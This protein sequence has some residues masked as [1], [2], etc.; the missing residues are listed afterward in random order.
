MSGLS[1][2]KGKLHKLRGGLELRPWKR[3]ST[4][5]QIRAAPTTEQYFLRLRQH[6]GPPATPVVRVGDPVRRWQEI[7]TSESPLSASLHA[8]VSGEVMAV[9]TDEII[10]RRQVENQ[11]PIALPA[12]DTR[13][14]SDSELRDRAH[15][16][17]LV[18]LGGASFP[19]DTKLN[20]PRPIE[21][22]II[23]GTECEPYITSDEML[24]RHRAEGVVSGSLALARAVNAKH[25]IVAVESR[26]PKVIEHLRKLAEND[27]AIEIV[28]V[29][30]RFP[31]G[32]ERQLTQILFWRGGTQRRSSSGHWRA[33]SQRCHRLRIPRG[34]RSRKT[35]GLTNRL[36]NWTRRT[37]AE[38]V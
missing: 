9:S 27:G 25:I 11:E 24:L 15:A 3:L 32:G 35:A 34:L 22:L 4:Q 19:T 6:P 26:L 31:E 16:A 10:I 7:A 18:G 21:M 5:G 17:G 13:S 28:G 23:N 29:P 36:N 2:A 33:V 8:P 1:F 30:Q 12:L 20:D 14:A 37:R 38:S